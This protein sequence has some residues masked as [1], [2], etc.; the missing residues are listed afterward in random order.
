MSHSL[1][2]HLPH[3]Y[4]IFTSIC[5]LIKVCQCRSFQACALSD[6][7]I[8]HNSEPVIIVIIIISLLH[9]RPSGLLWSCASIRRVFPKIFVCL[10]G[11]RKFGMEFLSRVCQVGNVQGRAL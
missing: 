3:S 8:T 5:I 9:P 10:V 11:D 2:I 7:S 4:S 6:I 1:Y